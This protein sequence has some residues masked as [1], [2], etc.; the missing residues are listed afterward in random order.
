MQNSPAA[1]TVRIANTFSAILCDALNNK[2]LAEV[3]ARNRVEEDRIICHSHDFCD[4]NEYMLEACQEFGLDTNEAEVDG[5]EPAFFEYWRDAWHLA[6]KSEFAQIEIP[7]ASLAAEIAPLI[8]AAKN[9]PLSD[10]AKSHLEEFDLCIDEDL[11]IDLEAAIAATT[12]CDAMPPLELALQLEFLHLRLLADGDKKWIK[13]GDFWACQSEVAL[14]N[15]VFQI[16]MDNGVDLEDDDA[17]NY[18][19][20]A[21]TVEIAEYDISR[22]QKHIEQTAPKAVSL[23]I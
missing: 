2:Q 22:I 4:P 3:V 21:T 5:K 9:A 6:K 19:L 15:L 18:C 17:L 13:N 1:K 10:S 8:V 23:G 14:G 12:Q 7:A 16:A 20:K 11:G